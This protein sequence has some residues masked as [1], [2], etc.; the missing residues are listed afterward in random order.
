MRIEWVKLRLDNWALWKARDGAGGLGFSSTTS[1]LHEVDTSR[2][3][4]S[5][6]P[7]DEVDASVTDQAV[8]TLK[9][10]REHLYQTLQAIYIAGAGIRE[11]SR[12]CGVGESTIKARLEQSDR[13]LANWFTDR[14]QRQA[15]QR[16]ELEA[17]IAQ[18]RT[19]AGR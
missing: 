2:Y 7:V 14:Q 11:A 1:F 10:D 9:G 17:R 12:Q 16:A 13:I 5:H 19:L 15:E 8:E 6:I 3:R 4:E 18:A